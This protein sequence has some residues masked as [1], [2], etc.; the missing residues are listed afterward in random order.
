MSIA[1]HFIPFP[2][3]ET[4]RLVLSQ[5]EATDLEPMYNLAKQP[6]LTRY[7]LWE[8][9]KNID[10]TRKFLN[11]LLTGYP[12]GNC[13]IWAIRRKDHS[14]I[15]LI[16]INGT[17]ERHSNTGVGYWLGMPYWNNGYMTEALNAVIKFSFEVLD[18]NRVQAEHV[19][20]N[21]AS[22]RVMQKCGMKFEGVLRQH[23]YA[24]NRFHDCKMY[25]ILQEEWR[26]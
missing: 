25:S 4:E 11:M 8:Y 21:P 15:G 10:E 23:L 2:V 9:H 20:D 5:C 1:D 12:I 13:Q 18:L 19:T 26:P 3:L 14:F 6:E 7:M 22:G 16:D 24:H 17:S